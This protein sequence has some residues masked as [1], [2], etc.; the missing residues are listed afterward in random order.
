MSASGKAFSH[1]R[2]DENYVDKVTTFHNGRV[3][4]LVPKT[5]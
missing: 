3:S 5:S 2:A 4:N 1:T